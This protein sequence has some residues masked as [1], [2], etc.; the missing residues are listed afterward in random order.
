MMDQTTATLITGST[1]AVVTIGS[2]LAVHY[3]TRKREVEGR[4]IAAAQVDKTKRLEILLSHHQRQIEEFY[5][6]IY[7]LI[8]LIWNVWSVKRDLMSKL[9]PEDNGKNIEEV[10][11]EIDEFIGSKFFAPIHHEIRSIL[12]T[13]LYLIEGAKM[14]PSFYEYLGHAIMEDVQSKLWQEAAISTKSVHGKTWPRSF[15]KDIKA[16]FDKA[17]RSYQ[18]IIDKLEE[19]QPHST[20][21]HTFGNRAKVEAGGEFAEVSAIP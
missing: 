4:L 15:P 7:S 19:A 11:A 18:Q 10:K 6:P 5:G 12:K 16:G 21:T 17:M 9:A 2:W 13:K 1:T 14:P 3:F 8:Q 20:A